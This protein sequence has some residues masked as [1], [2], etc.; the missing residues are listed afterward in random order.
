M[1]DSSKTELATPRRRN[2]AREQGQV[3][4]SRELPNVLALAGMASVLA[5][6]APRSLGHWRTLYRSMLNV[7]SSADLDANGPLLFWGGVEVMRWIV[8]IFPAGMTLSAF[9]A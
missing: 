9:A 7:A 4:R 1:A 3:A 5:I 8:P 2:K 6:M